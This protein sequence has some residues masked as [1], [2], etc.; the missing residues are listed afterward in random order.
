[1]KLGKN[2]SD[3]CSLLP[4]AYGG[5]AVKYSSVFEWHKRFKEGRED[6]ED[7]DNSH[8]LITFYDIKDNFILNS[9]H[10]AKKP[11]RNQLHEAVR[12]KVCWIFHHDNATAHKA[13]SA[14]Q[15]LA[16]KSITEMNTHPIYLIWLRMTSG[17]FQK[18]SLP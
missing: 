16:K 3:T 18:Y 14:K 2:A 17:C 5:E 10:K 4:E 1:M 9:S 12:K 8:M 6:V 11:I 13:L 15:L 7:E